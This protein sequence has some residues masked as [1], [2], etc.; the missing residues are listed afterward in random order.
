MLHYQEK[1]KLLL[2]RS[3]KLAFPQVRQLIEKPFWMKE[4][5]E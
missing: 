2:D 5:S 4:E 3:T 1:S